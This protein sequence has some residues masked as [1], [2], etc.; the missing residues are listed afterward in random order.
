GLG[1]DDI[2]IIPRKSIV[3]SRKETD[4][5]TILAK[6]IVIKIPIISSNMINV[7]EHKMAIAMAREGGIGIIHRF[8]SIE[9]QVEE[10]KRVKRAENIVIEDPYTI[11]KDKTIKE[12]KEEMK[13]LNVNGLLIEE[14][15]KLIGIITK[16]DVLLADDSERVCDVMTSR[17][18]LIFAKYGI[19]IDEAMKIFKK[20]KIEKLPL[21]DDRGFIKGLITLKDLIS[22]KERSNATKDKKGRL[23]V[24]AAIGVKD[25]LERTRALIDC[26]TD[27][28]VLDVAHAHSDLVIK[29]IKEIRREFGDKLCLIAGNVATEEG[30]SDLINAGVDAVKVGIGSGSICITRIVT[31]CGVPQITA[32]MKCSKVARKENIPIISDGGIKNSG[33]IAKALVAGASSVMIGSLLAGTDE[34]P[35]VLIVRNGK[36]YKFY[37]G[38]ASSL[39]NIE[40]KFVEGI[41]IN[42]TLDYTPEGLEA[43]VP[44]KGSVK[45]VLT[46]LVNGLKSAMSYCGV[47]SVIELN[48]NVKFIKVNRIKETLPEIEF[49]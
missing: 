32:I 7:T 17:E 39:S 28:I 29:T 5:S 1:F 34:S 48:S 11:K 24:G 27:V 46:Q 43:I 21:I 37:K 18:D 42:E 14:N 35:G 9:K 6:D 16:R 23:M 4:V 41:Q 22:L 30:T 45:D 12:V 25:W 26:E 40:K 49:I 38:M 8:M 2:L 19:T 3:E 15:G 47:K 33:D 13:R 36:K 10:V 44:Y 31:G 20:Y